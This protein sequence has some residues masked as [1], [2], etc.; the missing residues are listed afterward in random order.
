MGKIIWLASYPKSGNTWLRAFLHNLLSDGQEPYD[1]NQ[2]ARFTAGDSSM[3]WYTHLDPR[4]AE[5]FSKED[6]AALRPRAHEVIAQAFPQAALVKTHNA[7]VAD[8]GTAMITMQHT[9]G[10]IYVIRNPL[11]VVVSYANHNGLTFDRMIEALNTP[12]HQT[13]NNADNC[14]EVRGSW[15][16]HVSSWTGNRDPRVR[17]VRYEDMLQRPGETFGALCKFLNVPVERERLDSAIERCSFGVLQEQERLRGFNERSSRTERFF[18]V[19]KA[20]QWR[21]VLT[22]L[23]VDK[24]VAAHRDQMA[25]FGYWPLPEND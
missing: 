21:K 6:I 1:I 14:Y 20:G 4:P 10:A 9:A 8:R 2:L 13:N 18:R 7:M 24:V 11:D 15:S 17:A 5:S 16:E 22:S 19:G 12:G 23:Q 25:R 3:H